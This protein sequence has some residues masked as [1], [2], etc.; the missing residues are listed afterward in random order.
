MNWINGIQNALDYIENHMTDIV[1]L[2]DNRIK[3]WYNKKHE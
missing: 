1:I 3:I 2:F